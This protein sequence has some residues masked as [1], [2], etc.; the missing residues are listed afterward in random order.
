MTADQPER[1]RIGELI[2]DVG[3]GEVRR[4]GRR[5]TIP[6][7]TFELLL[8]LARHYPATARRSA[9]LEE[10]WPD[11]FVT[12]QTLTHR[13]MVLRKALGDHAEDA[14][15]VASDRGWGYR[16]VA[17]VEKLASPL[18]SAAASPTERPGRGRLM[19]GVILALLTLS[20]GPGHVVPPP[21]PI[22]V[23]PFVQRVSPKDL[24]VY[25]EELA[26]G[27]SGQLLRMPGVKLVEWAE[28]SPP[29]LWFEGQVEGNGDQ[30]RLR[31]QLFDVAQPGPVWSRD[32]AG[33]YDELRGRDAQ[34]LREA[35]AAVRGHVAPPSNCGL[36]A[37]APPDVE[38]LCLR[39]RCSWLSWSDEGLRRARESW[40]RAATLA[41]DHAPAAAGLSLVASVEG[42]MG[43]RA[44]G[45]AGDEAETLARLALGLDPAL[46]DAHLALG[47]ARLLYRADTAGA[48]RSLM[49]ARAMAPDDLGAALGEAL[50]LQV[51]G[52]F[53][54]PRGAAARPGSRGGVGRFSAAAGPRARGPR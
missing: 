47:L 53:G 33:R 21:T 8:S 32:Q 52:R 18:S 9:L 24:E 14:A 28:A 25:A 37:V 34:I 12:D 17:P 13:V 5:L 20:S 26:G 54:E 48:E 22:A 50:L 36:A 38:G 29:R 1:F 41:P 27:L 11:E 51:Q 31:L 40:L 35:A 46:P 10:V 45:E 7:R 2:L 49:R 44:A 39:G 30:L 6:P 43:Q 15:Y 42:L 3:A 19:L 23:R 16:L 4:R